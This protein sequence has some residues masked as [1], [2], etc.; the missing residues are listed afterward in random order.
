MGSQTGT[1]CGVA[2]NCPKAFYKGTP[3]CFEY[4]IRRYCCLTAAISDQYHDQYKVLFNN[5]FEWSFARK[6]SHKEVH[7]AVAASQDASVE[8]LLE[9]RGI[10]VS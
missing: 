5:F 7:D 8:T 6:R 9:K 3:P 2:K 4:Q 10:M 1:A